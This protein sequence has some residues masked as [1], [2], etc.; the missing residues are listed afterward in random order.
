M[1]LGPC[2]C[3]P[4]AGLGTG[5]QFNSLSSQG[6]PLQSPFAHIPRALCFYTCIKTTFMLLFSRPF[7]CRHTQ[8]ILHFF[9]FITTHVNLSPLLWQRCFL[10]PGRLQVHSPALRTQHVCSL[11]SLFHFHTIA[12]NPP[13]SSTPATAAFFSFPPSVHPVKFDL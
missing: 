5:S 4:G 7:F 11:P 3:E 6:C 12:V 2:R 13:L 8:T 1:L 9:I 10:C